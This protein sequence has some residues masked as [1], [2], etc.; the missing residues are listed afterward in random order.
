MYWKLLG[1]TL[2]AFFIAIL[3]NYA[4]I[5]DDWETVKYIFNTENAIAYTFNAL[6]TT[7]LVMLQITL[8][9][10]RLG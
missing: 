6:R 2:K 4:T 3:N 9:V 7:K 5:T 8:D 1:A 10:D